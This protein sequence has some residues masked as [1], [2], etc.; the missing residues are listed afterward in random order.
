MTTATAYIHLP[1]IALKLRRVSNRTRIAL[2]SG[3]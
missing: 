3:I 2:Q 1:G